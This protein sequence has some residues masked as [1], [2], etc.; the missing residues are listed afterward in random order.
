MDYISIYSNPTINKNCTIILTIKSILYDMK[1]NKYIRYDEI[2][3]LLDR[4]TFKESLLIN[5]YFNTNNFIGLKY[6]LIDLK[7]KK[8]KEQD[9]LIKNFRK[10]NKNVY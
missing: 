3:S 1:Y 5:K 9:F 8:S 10:N 6:C 2:N 4:L 7:I